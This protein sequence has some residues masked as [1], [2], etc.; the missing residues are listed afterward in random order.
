M[1]PTPL[2]SKGTASPSRGGAPCHMRGSVGI[3][4]VPPWTSLL[5]RGH[6]G[7]MRL[8]GR[9]WMNGMQSALRRG[10]A[11]AHNRGDVKREGRRVARGKLTPPTVLPGQFGGAEGVSRAIPCTS[12]SR[13]QNFEAIHPQVPRPGSF[14]RKSARSWDPGG[15]WTA[16]PGAIRALLPSPGIPVWSASPLHPPSRP[17]QWVPS[18]RREIRDVASSTPPAL[19]GPK[20]PRPARASAWSPPPYA[21]DRRAA[22]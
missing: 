22:H 17:M 4:T 8:D 18:R 20:A 6:S 13:V 9:E 14:R 7:F 10:C 1:R 5:P 11:W 12:G 3:G 2:S 16:S 19:R 21:A 15:I